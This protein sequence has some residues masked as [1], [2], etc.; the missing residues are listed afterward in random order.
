MVH[1]T[2]SDYSRG[3]PYGGDSELQLPRYQFGRGRRKHGR[4]ASMLSRVNRYFRSLIQSVTEAKLRRMR[5]DLELHG[6]RFDGPDDE[7]IPHSLRKG[8]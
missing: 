5:R 3:S 4:S 8:N 1:Y 7:W 2:I 6:I